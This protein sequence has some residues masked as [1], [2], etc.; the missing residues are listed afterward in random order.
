M[1]V[2]QQ[3]L[4]QRQG[5]KYERQSVNERVPAVRV[6]G[7]DGVEIALHSAFVAKRTPVFEGN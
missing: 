7:F 6:A 5:V 1:R 4:S 3:A 2:A